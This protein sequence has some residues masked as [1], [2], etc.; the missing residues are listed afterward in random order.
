MHVIVCICMCEIQGRNSFRG[1]GGGGGGNVNT[2]E[3]SNFSEKWKNSKLPLQCRLKT[4][5]FYRS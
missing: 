1:G 5:K 4:L 2:R 3:K